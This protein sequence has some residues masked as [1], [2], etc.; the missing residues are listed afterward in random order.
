[1]S[2]W[3]K[4]P[5]SFPNAV[6]Q[7]SQRMGSL[8]RSSYLPIVIPVMGW[9]TGLAKC[10]R[11]GID[12]GCLHF[13]RNKLEVD[14]VDAWQANAWRASWEMKCGI[15]TWMGPCL[16]AGMDWIG[17]TTLSSLSSAKVGEVREELC[18][19]LRLGVGVKG[20]G[21]CDGSS[22]AA[23]VDVVGTSGLRRG[24]CRGG[25]GLVVRPGLL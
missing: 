2:P 4:A 14:G 24:D 19:S 20:Y 15:W 18:C 21:S 11:C 16:S 25:V 23:E 8:A 22:V 9:T 12:V 13:G 17:M 1:M 5:S 6:V 7:V 3:A 10:S